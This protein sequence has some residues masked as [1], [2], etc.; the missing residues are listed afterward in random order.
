MDGRHHRRRWR[1]D[2]C[3]KPLGHDELAVAGEIALMLGYGA[4]MKFLKTRNAEERTTL[5]ALA[6]AAR[7]VEQEHDSDRANQVANEVAR[8][9][10]AS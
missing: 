7:A 5:Q 9:F 3:G 6:A 2:V 10:S 8:R 1:G 4:A